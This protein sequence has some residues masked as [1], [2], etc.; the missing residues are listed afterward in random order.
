MPYVIQSTLLLLGP[1]L[2]AATLYMTL[3]R[4]ILAVNGQKYAPIRPRWLTA[5]FVSGDVFSFIVQASGAGLRVQAGSGNSD[6]DPNLGSYIIVGGLILQIVIFAFFIVT[7]VV[8]NRRFRRDSH[9]AD[10]AIDV[11]WQQN[12]IML[13][14]TSGFIM[15]RNI[16]RVVEYAMGSDGYLLSVEWGVYV[17]DASLMTLTMALFLWRYPHQL[18]SAIGVHGQVDV[19][20]SSEP[21]EK[22]QSR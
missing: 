19:E 18:K 9:G 16:F 10:G 21:A 14:A 20:R 8:F 5:I 1:I 4:I 11:P 12:L 6:I 17:F 7:A 22:N 13:Y 3:S 2:L 15:I